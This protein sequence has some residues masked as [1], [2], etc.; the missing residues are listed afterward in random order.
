MGDAGRLEMNGNDDRS[1]RRT[2]V[3]MSGRATASTAVTRF[4]FATLATT[5]DE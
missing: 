1:G 5:S 2:G 4:V 3:E